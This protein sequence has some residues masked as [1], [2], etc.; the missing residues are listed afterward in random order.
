MKLSRIEIE[1][2]LH[3]WNQA[4]DNH[5][6]DGV[7][8][9]FHDEVYFENWTGGG[10]QGKAALE[11]AYLDKRRWTRMSILNVARCGKFSSDRTIR[12]YAKE[13]WHVEGMAIPLCEREEEENKDAGN[14]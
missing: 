5:D 6:L 9:L 2:A 10:A 7:M 11:K 4:W 8:A 14:L 12:E 1:T 3:K 13:I